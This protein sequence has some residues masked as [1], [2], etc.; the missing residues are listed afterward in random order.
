M[1]I[2]RWLWILQVNAALWFVDLHLLVQFIVVCIISSFFVKYSIKY[3][4]TNTATNVRTPSSLC[5]L[6]PHAGVSIVQQ[7]R[8]WTITMPKTVKAV[9]GSC[10]VVPCQTEP[11]SRVI[12]YQYHNTHYPVL[13]DGH[14]P[15]KV[16]D[17]FRGRT[18]VKGVAAEG[19]CTLTIYD[20]RREE[21]YLQ[22][23]VWINPESK[24]PQ[25]FYDQTV[26][27]IVGK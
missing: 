11:H 3:T 8:G 16:E 23:Y 26:T 19:N 24:A 9:E 15:F 7:V 5:L 22:V 21:N 18:T 17:Q 12:W 14:R 20:M 1:L 4:I 6:S 2:S 13:Y 10:A 27:I 25:R